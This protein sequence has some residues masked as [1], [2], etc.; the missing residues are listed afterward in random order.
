MWTA[1]TRRTHQIEV[2]ALQGLVFLGWRVDDDEVVIYTDR[3]AALFTHEQDCCERVTVRE[4]TGFDARGIGD[5]IRIAAE[6]ANRG[7]HPYGTETYT[8]YSIQTDSL[9]IAMDW[10]GESNGHYSEDV[11]LHLLPYTNTRWMRELPDDQ[12]VHLDRW[13]D[14]G[15]V[16]RT[17]DNREDPDA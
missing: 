6:R 5:T 4:A 2:E 3:G 9:D 14:C 17:I 13:I 12:Q 10:F 15:G 7:E 16:I 8:F 11:D 1:E